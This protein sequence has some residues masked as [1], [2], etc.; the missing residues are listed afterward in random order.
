MQKVTIKKES[1]YLNYSRNTE[2]DTSGF[3]F[4]NFQTEDDVVAFIVDDIVIAVLDHVKKRREV[5]MIFINEELPSEISHTFVMEQVVKY[6]N[7]NDAYLCSENIKKN[8]IFNIKDKYQYIADINEYESILKEIYYNNDWEGFKGRTIFASNFEW[9]K[10]APPIKLSYFFAANSGLEKYSEDFQAKEVYQSGCENAKVAPNCSMIEFYAYNSGLESYPENFQ[11]DHVYQS[12]CQNSKVAPNCKL[13][14]FKAENS[15]LE[16]YPEGF[17]ANYVNQEGCINAKIA[18]NCRTGTFVAQ[19]SGLE[20]YPENFRT[21]TLFIDYCKNI[22]SAPN[23]IMDSFYARSS[24]FEYYPEGFGAKDINQS[25]CKNIKVA[26]NYDKILC[27]IADKSVLEVIPKNFKAKEVMSDTP[28]LYNL[29][30]M[31]KLKE[32]VKE[33]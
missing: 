27:F 18:P 22:K 28:A 6:I 14:T 13:K 24:S 33:F 17:Q 30:K 32:K 3:K 8:N 26:P 7:D 31:K 10:I 20:T 2:L 12:K 4:F 23:F 11:A 19:N 9:F 29:I 5:K 25:Y 1:N 21:N 16:T 15:G